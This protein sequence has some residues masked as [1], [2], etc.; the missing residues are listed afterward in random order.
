MSDTENDAIS[1]QIKA[2]KQE[3]DAVE[4]NAGWN[5]GLAATAGTAIGGVAGMVGAAGVVSNAIVDELWR[6]SQ[7]TKI[8]QEA[9]VKDAEALTS[10]GM[11]AM[12][13]SATTAGFLLMGLP[14]LCA[15]LG[16]A[17]STAASAS[18]SQSLR[19]KIDTLKDKSWEE[20]CAAHKCEGRER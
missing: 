2:R 1:R 7:V 8:P 17:W 5:A 18:K 14:A 19:S 11:S 10:I 6:A 9:L 15:A 3:L 20:R 16:A 12:N 13:R 4:S